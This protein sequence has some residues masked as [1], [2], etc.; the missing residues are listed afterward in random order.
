MPSASAAQ[1]RAAIVR[2]GCG[3]C[4]AIPGVRWPQ[5]KVGPALGGLA[6]R[7]LIAGRLPNRPDT[8]AAYIRNAPAMVPQSAMPAMPV[9]EAEARN[10]AAYLYAQ[11]A[12]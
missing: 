10:I 8:L 9:S 7:G 6:E 1:G 5:G 2:V 3:S 4:H 12:S 11:G